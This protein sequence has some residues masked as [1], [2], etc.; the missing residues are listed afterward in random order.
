MKTTTIKRDFSSLVIVILIIIIYFVAYNIFKD[1]YLYYQGR[2]QDNLSI[3]VSNW[4]E[5]SAGKMRNIDTAYIIF[6]II[7]SFIT[8]IYSI[9]KI[10]KHLIFIAVYVIIIFFF[11]AFY[12]ISL[13]SEIKNN[14]LL[15]SVI[16]FIPYVFFIIRDV[17]I[18]KKIDITNRIISSK[19]NN[20]NDIVKN[21]KSL[22]DANVISE[23]QYNNK[24][25]QSKRA[26]KKVNFMLSEEYRTLANL[27]NQ[28]IFTDDE[29]AMK[30]EEIIDKI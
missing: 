26:N 29:F 4:D 21:L 27:K 2:V 5:K 1:N 12:R 6:L 24:I 11:T 9:V 30:I 15:F 17:I 16:L 3:D 18:G 19:N 10:K 13:E 20:F 8:L 14:G 25:L 28:G 22:K 7:L 23:E